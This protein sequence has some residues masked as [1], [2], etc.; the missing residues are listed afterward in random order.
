MEAFECNC[1]CGCG[2]CCKQNSQILLP[3]A[4]YQLHQTIIQSNVGYE[5]Q[6]FSSEMNLQE[7]NAQINLQ[8]YNEIIRQNNNYY[9]QHMINNEWSRSTNTIFAES[10][11]N[12]HSGKPKINKRRN[13]YRNNYNPYYNNRSANTKKK[14]ITFNLYCLP[15]GDLSPKIPRK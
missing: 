7:I 6:N 4:P 13:N 11:N 2:C 12:D 15:Y 10:L 5:N 9:N 3:V 1:K 8:I 14:Q